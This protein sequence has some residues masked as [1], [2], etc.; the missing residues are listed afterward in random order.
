MV[1]DNINS[2]H[3]QLYK[4]IKYFRKKWCIDV[5]QPWLK[6]WYNYER[7]RHCPKVRIEILPIVSRRHKY[8]PL[9]GILNSLAH[10][11]KED[12]YN[13]ML[14]R[15]SPGVVW[16]TNGRIRISCP[17]ARIVEQAFVKRAAWKEDVLKIDRSTEEKKM[18]RNDDLPV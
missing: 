4:T 11:F 14:S 15:S 10:I 13:S 18:W 8:L 5:A 6:Y 3:K 2:I 7:N 16:Y 1:T 9:I 17:T 12:V